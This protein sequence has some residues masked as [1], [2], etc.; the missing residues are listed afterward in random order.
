MRI[1]LKEDVERLGK[2]GEIVDV[3]PGYAR[4]D[5]LPRG[6]AMSVSRQ[7]LEHVEALRKRY[8]KMREERERT[9]HEMF[10]RLQGASCTIMARSNEEGHLFG[11]VGPAQV[12]QALAAEGFSLDEDMVDLP[13]P[14]RQVGVYEVALLAEGDLAASC[15]VWVVSE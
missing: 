10:E 12:A 5:L 8:G 13:E 14:I 7:N 4:N 11:S 3:R 15:K 9:L 2:V 6:L 1:I